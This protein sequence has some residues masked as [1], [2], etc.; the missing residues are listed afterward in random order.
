MVDDSIRLRLFPHT[1][2]RNVAKWYFELPSALA[3]TFGA[4]QMEFLKKF[5]ITIHYETRMELLTTLRQDTST[6]IFDHIHEWRCRWRIVKAPI[7]G[8]LLADWFCKSLLPQ[9]SK[10]IALAGTIIEDQSI[11]HA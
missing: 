7:S 3:N 10:D 8:Y 4:L 5:Q 1:L 2:T 11:L 6:H 9:I